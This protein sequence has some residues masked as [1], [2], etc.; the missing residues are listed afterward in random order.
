M[1][2]CLLTTKLQVCMRVY[3]SS[4]EWK[5]RNMV[6]TGLCNGVKYHSTP[7]APLPHISQCSSDILGLSNGCS[8]GKG[9]EL[10]LA[11][12]TVIG[13]DTVM[14]RNWE[15]ADIESYAGRKTRECRQWNK[16]KACKKKGKERN[17][18]EIESTWCYSR[19]AWTTHV[20]VF[21][22][23]YYVQHC[24]SSGFM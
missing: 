23:E 21:I 7:P 12:G 10:H 8:Q 14:D 9:R 18:E 1:E 6:H 13:K 3:E 22:H 11:R 15:E 24:P 5:G 2:F 20:I 4:H 17:T 16:L 19:K